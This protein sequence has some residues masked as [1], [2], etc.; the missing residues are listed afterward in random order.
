[1]V[2]TAAQAADLPG[3]DKPGECL[4]HGL[5][6]AE[7]EEVLAGEYFTSTAS[8]NSI[9]DFGLDGY[10]SGA[11]SCQKNVSIFL[12]GVKPFLFIRLP[13]AF[14]FQPPFFLG[15]LRLWVAVITARGLDAGGEIAPLDARTWQQRWEQLQKLGGPP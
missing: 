10:H 9:K 3:P 1:V 11:C 7:I 8:A 12:T 5:A 15:R 4:V 6:R 13:W 14:R 2:Q